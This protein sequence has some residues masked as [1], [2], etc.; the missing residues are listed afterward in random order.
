MLDVLPMPSRG[1]DELGRLTR[2]RCRSRRLLLVSTSALAAPCGGPRV[3][4]GAH[5]VAPHSRAGWVRLPVRLFARMCALLVSS[6]S[7]RTRP[8]S[9]LGGWMS[10]RKRLAALVMS[11]L[12]STIPPGRGQ[13]PYNPERTPEGPSSP[14]ALTVGASPSLW[15]KPLAAQDAIGL[16]IGHQAPPAHAWWT[17]TANPSSAS[18]YANRASLLCSSSGRPV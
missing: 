11:E 18:N 7:Y 9:S 14:Y 4:R 17:W 16:P 6:A 2:G 3:P 1:S 12:R 13:L 15:L 5:P 8:A 10:G